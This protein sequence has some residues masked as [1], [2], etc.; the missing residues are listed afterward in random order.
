MGLPSTSPGS[1]AGGEPCS[2]CVNQPSG[3]ADLHQSL[4]TAELEVWTWVCRSRDSEQRFLSEKLGCERRERDGRW[5]VGWAVGCVTVAQAGS[6][7][8]LQVGVH[9]PGEGDAA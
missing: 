7:G 3:D 5:A 8:G 2:L 9:P 6:L 1:E 4:R